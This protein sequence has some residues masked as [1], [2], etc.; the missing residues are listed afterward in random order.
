MVNVVQGAVY[1]QQRQWLP[2]HDGHPNRA[3]PVNLNH[4]LGHPRMTLDCS[5]NL[6]L[7]NFPEPATAVHIRKVPKRP[8]GGMT[9]PLKLHDRDKRLIRTRHPSGQ[10]NQSRHRG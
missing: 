8:A 3:L 9:S 1:E 5:S 10:A 7:I 2:L 4:S 6:F